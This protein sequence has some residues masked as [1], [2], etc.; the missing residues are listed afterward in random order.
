MSESSLAAAAAALLL[1]I[2]GE[3]AGGIPGLL[4]FAATAFAAGAALS[5][6]M[7]RRRGAFGAL[8][9]LAA[10]ALLAALATVALIGTHREQA[11][12]LM[13]SH[14]MEKPAEGE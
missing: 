9:P 10:G 1:G 14:G 3:W 13:A 11:R 6:A 5:T 4:A 2:S 12:S 8:L 7:L